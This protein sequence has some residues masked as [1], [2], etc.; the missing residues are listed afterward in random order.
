M[1]VT[2]SSCR[3]RF[4]LQEKE[5]TPRSV[6]PREGMIPATGELGWEFWCFSLGLTVFS[7]AILLLF[8]VEEGYTLW[9]ARWFFVV[10]SAGAFLIVLPEMLLSWKR[11]NRYFF[12]RALLVLFFP[13]LFALSPSDGTYFLSFTLVMCS[14]FFLIP[15]H[16]RNCGE[17]NFCGFKGRDL[18]EYCDLC[19]HTWVQTEPFFPKTE[20][21][22]TFPQTWPNWLNVLG[23]LVWVL[24]LV[25]GFFE[26]RKMALFPAFLGTVCFTLPGIWRSLKSKGKQELMKNLAFFLV[27]P[28]LFLF[29]FLPWFI[30]IS[31]FLILV[32]FVALFSFGLGGGH[33][34]RL[35][36]QGFFWVMTLSLLTM[37]FAGILY[38]WA[39]TIFEDDFI[40]EIYT[41]PEQPLAGENFTV[42]V[43][44]VDLEGNWTVEMKYRLD[45]GFVNTT[46]LEFKENETHAVEMAGLEKGTVFSYHFRIFDNETKRQTTDWER[47]VVA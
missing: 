22:T 10:F 13:G 27:L 30:Y 12:S 29:A 24:A 19:G 41:D 20:H 42:V 36:H 43:V 44:L 2:C 8:E 11:R 1:E 28:V 17:R 9:E 34:E 25:L 46:K 5:D 18:A 7:L 45:D 35:F 23:Q 14:V 26:G 38:Q 6:G 33:N 16:C 15:E 3:A 37:V 47:V 39:L 40:E 32:F 21:K 31:F 4:D